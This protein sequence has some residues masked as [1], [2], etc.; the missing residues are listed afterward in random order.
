MLMQTTS[1]IITLALLLSG[2]CF[3]VTCLSANGDRF[4]SSTEVA[5]KFSY[6]AKH[7]EQDVPSS[8]SSSQHESKHLRMYDQQELQGLQVPVLSN[9]AQNYTGVLP[10][11]NQAVTNAIYRIPSGKHPRSG[12][13]ADDINTIAQRFN[14]DPLLLHAIAYVESRYNPA[15][16]SPAGAKGMMQIMPATARRFGLVG[17]EDEL[18][19]PLVS[20]RISSVYLRKLY[21]LFGNDL[22]LVLAAYNAG[23]GAVMKYGRKIPPYRE[24]QAYV[25]KVMRHYLELRT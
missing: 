12:L 19:N 23:E 8:L 25:K 14:I 17:S 6:I 15:A 13:F 22:P 10:A 2:E 21:E 18:F 4:S 9:G 16:V 1:V 11:G 20:L 5:S 3:A 24:T 7:C